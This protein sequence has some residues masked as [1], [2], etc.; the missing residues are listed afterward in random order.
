[1]TNDNDLMIIIAVM[2]GVVMALPIG[3]QVLG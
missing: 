3:A 2:I 1:V